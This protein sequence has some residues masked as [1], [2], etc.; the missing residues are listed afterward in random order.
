MAT[1][2]RA[3]SASGRADSHREG[4]IQPI[5]TRKISPINAENLDQAHL[6][7]TEG[8]TL[9]KIVWEGWQFGARDSTGGTRPR[10]RIR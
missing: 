4:R 5:T 1:S 7:P 9:G 8:H 2:P 3:T 6:V 10:S